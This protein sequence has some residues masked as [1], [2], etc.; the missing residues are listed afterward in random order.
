MNHI[1]PPP[2]EKK[3]T[4]GE[5]EGNGNEW[6]EF[7]HLPDQKFTDFDSIRNEIIR[8]T[9]RVAGKGKAVSNNAIRLSV[10]SPNV[11][12]LTLVDLPGITKVPVGDQ[13]AD[14]ESQIRDMCV[15]FIKNP[16]SLILAVSPA[17]SDLANSEAI[18]LSKVV[19]PEGLRTVGVISKIDLMDA[20]TDALE[21]LQGKT[22][23]LK[24]G[25]VGVVNRSQADINKNLPIKE[26]LR[27]EALFF[28]SH[29]AYR[30]MAL[31]M[32]TPF[33]AK[34]LNNL[35][36]NH[37]RD[38]LP[39]IKNKINSMVSDNRHELEGL[40]DVIVL[41][42]KHSQGGVLLSLLSKYAS[43]FTSVIDGKGEGETAAVGELYGGARIA[44]IFN[45]VFTRSIVALDP[46]ENLSDDDIR[47][48]IR[49][50][51]GHRAALFV[52]E[53]SFELLVRRQIASIES[54]GL[55]CIDLVY[56]EIHR[57]TALA[58]TTEIL[59][60]GE[61]R[62]RIIEVVR[63]L[64]R[65]RLLSTRNMV[66]NLIQI[67][68]AHINTNH[69]DFVGGSRAVS[70][71]MEK[72][73]KDHED[74]L[75]RK[76]DV[77]Q[78]VNDNKGMNNNKSN[79]PPPLPSHGENK[80]EENNGGFMSYVWGG[81]SSSKSKPI[82]SVTAPTGGTSTTLPR[83]PEQ[84]KATSHATEREIIEVNIIKSLIASYFAIVRKNF[85]DLVPKV[86]FKKREFFNVKLTFHSF[87]FSI[88]NY[89]FSCKSCK[90]RTSK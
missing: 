26:A 80:K 73:A 34:T 29:A 81:S 24:L 53:M 45:E 30:S 56:D 50:A 4:E 43:N 35:L 69:P 28:K 79:P 21:M 15:E 90:A 20:G 6:G 46:F 17:N 57:I 86:K 72:M 51:N 3:K 88:G 44:Y 33:L 84:V 74:D 14:I 1:D 77:K 23:P 85:M 8:E 47:T 5:E 10:F 60:F 61:L 39:D 78:R 48:S 70:N 19:D 68:L 49:N 40:G 7:L 64:V 76:E 83:V 87:I 41:D 66:S 36:M 31:R 22:I 54:L 82:D 13:P 12:N 16:K 18:K 58:E 62:D 52:P 59:R 11:L 42:N 67:E 71:I 2:S 75:K 9:D 25:Y 55:Q 37:I 63:R 65:E 27:K 89:A 32:G 38:T